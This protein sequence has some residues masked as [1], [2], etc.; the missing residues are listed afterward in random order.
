[1]AEAYS[2]LHHAPSL[3]TLSFKSSPKLKESNKDGEGHKPSNELQLHWAMLGAI[4]HNP[5]SLPSLRSLT[6]QNMAPFPNPLYDTTPLA[7]IIRGSHNLHI[8]ALGAEYQTDIHFW[9]PLCD[10]WEQAQR[11]L[12]PDGKEFYRDG[13]NVVAGAGRLRIVSVV[14]LC[15]FA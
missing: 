4:A 11:S 15:T 8:S 3:R 1:M 5:H 6:L 7:T 2:L 14:F 10:F 12:S 9:D 13:G